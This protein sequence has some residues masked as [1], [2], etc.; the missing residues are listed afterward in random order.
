M[1]GLTSAEKKLHLAKMSY[2]DYLLQYAKVDKQ[3]IWFFQNVPAGVFAVGTDAT[4]ALFG[5]DMGLPG[6]RGLKLDP[7]P[8]GVLLICRAASM[9]GRKKAAPRSISPTATRP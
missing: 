2:N 4:P 1:P 3:V 5:W 6:F 8:D 7:T 9:G